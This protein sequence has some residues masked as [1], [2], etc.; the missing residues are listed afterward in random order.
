MDL[1]KKNAVDNKI[2]YPLLYDATTDTLKQLGLWSDHMAMPWM[3]YLIVDK[4]GRVVTSDLQLN[5][6]KGAGP[7]TVSQIIGAL[8]KSR[9]R[10]G[11]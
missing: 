1:A 8:D 3:G 10:D 6:A 11:P 2:T 5:E 9:L 7:S 4:S